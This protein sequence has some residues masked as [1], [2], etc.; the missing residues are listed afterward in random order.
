[1]NDLSKQ[2]VEIAI[3]YLGPGGERFMTRQ[4][5]A[6]LAGGVTLE[7]LA[8]E[9]LPELSKWVGIS[10]GLLLSDPSQ[11]AEFVEKVKNAA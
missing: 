4:V 5:E 8:P 6:H 9:H 1:M 2:L 7:T 10:A 11:V 3:S